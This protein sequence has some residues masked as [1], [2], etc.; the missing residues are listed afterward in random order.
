[1]LEI[2]S[3]DYF[4]TPS[5]FPSLLDEVRAICRLVPQLFS[6]NRVQTNG[7]NSLRIVLDQLADE[8]AAL[9][10]VL[11]PC[12]C[13]VWVWLLNGACQNG[14]QGLNLRDR[15]VGRSRETGPHRN[16]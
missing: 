6:Q 7:S 15:F 11:V 8:S 9:P 4:Q 16:R 12:T 13:S 14:I 2:V 3:D 5:P 1:M 10:Q